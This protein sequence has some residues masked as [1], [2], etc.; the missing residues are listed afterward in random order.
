MAIETIALPIA[1]AFFV[2][3]LVAL[4]LVRRRAQTG[5]WAIVVRD[6]STSVESFVRWWTVVLLAGV[7]V[8]SILV[9]MLGASTLGSWQPGPALSWAGVGLFLL[10][11]VIIGLAQAQMGTSWRIGIDDEPTD[12]VTTGLFRWVRHPIYSGILLMFV[13]VVCL[14][15]SPWTVCGLVV[16]YILVAL[17]SRLE[18]DH[19]RSQHGERFSMW[20]SA[21]GRFVPRVGRLS[22]HLLTL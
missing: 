18:E 17:Q 16:G 8:W 1:V 15:P 12:L 14:T 6:R 13:G 5:R 4:P 2:A 7:A 9:A 21:V 11:F 20:A 19:M 22:D 3:F 10:G